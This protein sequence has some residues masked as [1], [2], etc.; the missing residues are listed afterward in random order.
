MS[1]C[2]VSRREVESAA[3][4]PESD[5]CESIT[6][7]LG[8]LSLDSA[9]TDISNTAVTA[10]A[11]CRKRQQRA[12]KN[13]R[14]GRNGAAAA[15]EDEADCVVRSAVEP[16]DAKAE[17]VLA[18]AEEEAG[19]VLRAAPRRSTRAAPARSAARRSEAASDEPVAATELLRE[20][21]S[22]EDVLAA[23]QL[24]LCRQRGDQ[25]QTSG[26]S[27][28]NAAAA[29][30]STPAPLRIRSS[31]RAPSAG[32]DENAIPATPA[33]PTAARR[34]SRF[35]AMQVQA[36]EAPQTGL[37]PPRAR[38]AAAGPATAAAPSRVRRASDRHIE[39]APTAAGE[40]PGA[41]G[42][43]KQVSFAA[44]A[45]LGPAPQTPAVQPL[46]ASRVK[47][48]T[49]RKKSSA[50]KARQ[51][52]S[53]AEAPTADGREAG[54]CTTPFVIHRAADLGDLGPDV[55]DLGARIRALALDGS[56]TAMVPDE[57][58]LERGPVL[59]ILDR[60][61]QSL[62]WESLPALQRQRY[63]F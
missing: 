26:S 62:P 43:K 60:E 49:A 12:P 23:P 51:G 34:G 14:R 48:S 8:G 9:L 33:V 44:D 59:L 35:A 6:S 1:A 52:P 7:T 29:A 22:E 39:G 4:Q 37:L 46:A 38:A 45:Q 56:D 30:V 36:G 63:A 5:P 31:L 58:V 41:P 24:S 16:S 27:D 10:P 53:N 21:D 13:T 42:K 57:P 2:A 47:A 11:A 25:P 18:A 50:A 54:G 28:S 40:R 3:A 17:A 61:L 55:G 32:G 20:T 15:A 19:C